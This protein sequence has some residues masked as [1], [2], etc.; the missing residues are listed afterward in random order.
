MASVCVYCG[1]NTG[2]ELSFV[3]L[4]HELGQTI[5]DRGHRLVYGGGN[6]GL[7]R[8]VADAAMAARG[9][10]VGVMTEQLVRLEVA[11]TGLTELEVEPSMHARKA[12]MAELSDGVIVAPGGYGTWEE[13]MEILT[14][15]QLGLVSIPVVFLDIG[16]FYRH[17][18]EM[19]D[20]ANA[21]G[22]VSD[23]NRSLALRATDA[24]EA[25]ELATRPAP[26]Y[27]PKWVD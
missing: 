3:E 26:G 1:S 21:A 18:F 22:F 11:H 12:R 5:A 27:E 4:M 20:A 25:V 7:M 24:A 2:V 13:A 16:G 8:I 19:F 9:E 17:L 14:W 15:N 23:H 6:V 10:V